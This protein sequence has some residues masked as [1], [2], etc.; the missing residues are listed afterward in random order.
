LTG[1]HFVIAD[2]VREFR[3]V[4]WPERGVLY[5]AGGDTPGIYFARVDIPCENTSETSFA[6]GFQ[7][8]R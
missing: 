4:W 2:D 6:C 7:G 3:D 1:D 5:A 8:A